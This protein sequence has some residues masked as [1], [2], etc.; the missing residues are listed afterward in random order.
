MTILHDFA[1][2]N[3]AD[4]IRRSLLY[5]NG[6]QFLL[7]AVGTGFL[8]IHAAAAAGAIEAAQELLNAGCPIDARTTC[9][10]E[11]R[12]PLMIA[13]KFGQLPMVKFLLENN[14]DIHAE[15]EDTFTALRLAVWNRQKE[16]TQYL[17]QNG[18]NRTDEPGYE[19]MGL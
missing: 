1:Q 17:L 11:D 16:V 8:P 9:N 2:N 6:R 4:K 15:D 10:D 18:A 13:A 19:E 12:T 7:T 3:Q 14:A 5:G